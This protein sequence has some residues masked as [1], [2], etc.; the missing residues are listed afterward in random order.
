MKLSILGMTRLIG[1]VLLIALST[2]IAL[3]TILR[4]FNLAILGT[5]DISSLML[6]MMFVAGLADAWVSR[7]NVR[8]DLIYHL[9]PRRFR[10]C[11]D[12]VATVLA[13]VFCATLAFVA[14]ENIWHFLQVGARTP[15]VRLPHWIFALTILLG[16]I[17]LAIAIFVDTYRLIRY[18]GHFPADTTLNGVE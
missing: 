7:S 12:L 4:A 18:R 9:C 16:A 13:T 6:L 8:M 1:G 10:L 2:I 14:Y 3:D 5:Q 17:T 15:I 11:V